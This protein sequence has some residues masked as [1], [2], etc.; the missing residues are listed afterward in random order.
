MKAYLA[1]AM[2]GLPEHGFP[3]FRD[4]AVDLRA[5][6]LNIVSPVELDESEG[7][8]ALTEP[9]VSPGS[10]KW[11]EFLARDVRVVADPSIEAV[12]VLPGWERSRGANLEVRVARSLGKKILRYPDLEPVDPRPLDKALELVHGNRGRDYG[13]PADDFARTAGM[14][15]ALFGWD[16]EPEDVALAMICVK[17]SRLRQTPDHEDSP[18]DVAGYAETFVMVIE[19]Q[20]ELREAEQARRAAAFD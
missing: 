3:L 11:A 5:R 4:A 2:S 14:W 15:H 17:L 12:I 9:D 19:R 7:F 16:V 20:Q 10:E 13:H 18:V 6:G 1:G 8:D